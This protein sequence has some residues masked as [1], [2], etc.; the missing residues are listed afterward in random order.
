MEYKFIRC[1]KEFRTFIMNE[2]DDELNDWM[3]IE[4]L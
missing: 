1:A 4:C 3:N 2:V